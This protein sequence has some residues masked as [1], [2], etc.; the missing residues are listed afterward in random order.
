MG[1]KSRK[2]S[3]KKD[4][5]NEIK[6]FIVTIKKC[7]I[8]S[9]L[10][11]NKEGVRI[12]DTVLSYINNESRRYDSIKNFVDHL[13]L[14]TF[15]KYGFKLKIYNIKRYMDFIEKTHK[16]KA[17]ILEISNKARTDRLY[18]LS[19]REYDVFA[20]YVFKKRYK[21]DK[22]SRYNICGAVWNR[23]HIK[24]SKM[25][26]IDRIYYNV[27][28]DHSKPRLSIYD[29]NQYRIGEDKCLKS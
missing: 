26:T 29:H 18:P 15:I 2:I 19:N 8:A 10:D 9:R 11:N 4:L 7:K 20:N 25:G 17:K 24:H 27:K 21:K 16:E 1:Y 14:D 13:L 22:Y 5:E 3:K 28:I 6:T 12:I 23:I